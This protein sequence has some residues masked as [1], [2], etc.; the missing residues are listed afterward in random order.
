[1]MGGEMETKRQ[2]FSAG[3]KLWMSASVTATDSSGGAYGGKVGMNPYLLESAWQSSSRRA[4][5]AAFSP[6]SS[7]L[8][9]PF[10]LTGDTIR[11]TAKK[12]QKKEKSRSDS[13]QTK[14][15]DG[16]CLRKLESVSTSFSR[17]HTMTKSSKNRRAIKQ[18]H[19]NL[20]QVWISCPSHL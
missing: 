8:H 4:T 5:S 10:P 7:W 11:K 20:V 14:N 6:P 1:M 13:H 16:F 3:N 18:K 2:I 19:L 12:R 15:E 17:E 9:A